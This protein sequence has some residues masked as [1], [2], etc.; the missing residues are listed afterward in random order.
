MSLM[1]SLST[2]APW[3]RRLH[4]QV[5]LALAGGAGF[6]LAAVYLG[7]QGWARD[8]VAPFGTVFMNLLKFVALPMVVFSVISGIASIG[9]A[10]QLSRLGG[11][12]LLWFLITA[13]IAVGIGLVFAAT[14]RPGDALPREASAQLMAAYETEAGARDAKARDLRTEGPLRLLVEAVPDNF[15]GALGDNTRMLQV[16]VAAIFIGWMLLLLPKEQAQPLVTLCGSAGALF[17]KMGHAVAML[18]PL[19]VFALIT[20]TIIAIS[21]DDPS[22][23]LRLLE[24]L[25]LYVLTVASALAFHQFVIY[26]LIIRFV[27]GRSPRE[28]FRGIAPAQLLCFSTSS[29]SA[30]LPVTLECCE[31]NLGVP[32]RIA[33]FVLP[34]ATT[35]NMDGSSMYQ[36]VAAVFIAQA[37]GVAL[38]AADYAVI[39]GACLVGGVGTAPVPGSGLVMLMMVLSAA[40]LPAEGLALV[41]GVDRLVNMCRS[42]V[43]AV[44]DAVVAVI[45]S[46]SKADAEPPDKTAAPA[47]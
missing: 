40:G 4:W 19:G 7:W 13:V 45:L 5:L 28:F 41:I 35:I 26:S 46:N 43:N 39:F 14:L 11:R 2:T 27:A 3:Y 22:Q 10:R 24:A 33:R 25:A 21:G 15:L 30:S 44:G 8:W 42:T 38:G 23:A 12:A 37:L 18:S 9:D 47:P 31:K 16:V 32:P 20:G 6:G 1:P 34:L 17:M 29:T 36:A